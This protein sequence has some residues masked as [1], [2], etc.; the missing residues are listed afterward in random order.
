MDLLFLLPPQGLWQF[1]KKN[2]YLH[3]AL[4]VHHLVVTSL[5]PCWLETE[6]NGCVPY[7][8]ELTALVSHTELGMKHAKINEQD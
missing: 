5:L 6:L 1:N 2:P 3:Q 8:W 4:S 7:L